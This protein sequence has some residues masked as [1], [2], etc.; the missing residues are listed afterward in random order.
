MLHSE[1]GGWFSAKAE[2]AQAVGADRIVW[3]RSKPKGS[4][5]K[6]SKTQLSSHRLRTTGSVIPDFSTTHGADLVFSD[7]V[8][9]GCS[10]APCTSEITGC[11]A[12]EG[13]TERDSWSQE[14]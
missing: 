8:A 7:I 13:A 3:R 6:I 10:R 14:G 11:L 1:Q 5:I 12:D 9:E 4:V 2:L